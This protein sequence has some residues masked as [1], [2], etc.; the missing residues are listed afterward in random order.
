MNSSLTF[1]QIIQ[2]ELEAVLSEQRQAVFKQIPS[3]KFNA[4]R[5]AKQLYDAKG[6]IIDDEELALKA[7]RQIKNIDQYQQVFSALKNMP[8]RLIDGGARPRNIAAY[9]KSF[10]S[11]SDRIQAAIHLYDVL[12][13]SHY[14]WTIKKLV[15]Y[16]DLKSALSALAGRGSRYDELRFGDLPGRAINQIRKMFD[17]TAMYK[18]IAQQDAESERDGFDAS[19]IL[20]RPFVS[21]ELYLKHKSLSA[22]INA[23]GGLRE[24]VYSPAGIGVT[25]ATSLIPSPWTQIPTRILFAVL[26]IDDISRAAQGNNEA[27]LDIIWDSLGIIGGSSLSKIGKSIGSKFAALLAWIKN[28]GILAKIS[29]K[30]F[31]ILF[32]T[33]QFISKT[34]LGPILKNGAK[35]VNAIQ[36]TIRSVI[37]KALSFVKDMLIKLKNMPQPIK[38]WAANAL[39][40]LKSVSVEYYMNELKPIFDT[41]QLLAKAVKELFTAPK[42]AVLD[43]ARRLGVKSDWVVGV[44][45]GAQAAWV[46]Q[47]FYSIPSTLSWWAEWYS[48]YLTQQESYKVAQELKGILG[49]ETYYTFKNKPNLNI[50]M[51]FPTDDGV[52]LSASYTIPTYKLKSVPGKK[53]PMYI[54]L[55]EK[56]S[57][58]AKIAIPSQMRNSGEV[59]EAW[60]KISDIELAPKLK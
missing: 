40:N 17:D 13:A 41:M 2:E 53:I 39:Q 29:R 26:V 6:T 52:W 24:M 48:K 4:R 36:S 44:A 8:D 37:S 3:A 21:T 34:P 57:G 51:Y 1:E 50:K 43:V 32:D 42:S 20:F 38:S 59:S 15:S 25:T 22:W 55:K 12:P 19:D 18:T 5:I 7:I 10:L 14:N 49:S 23:P 56:K 45:H 31:D 47:M 9:L 33:I 60:V 30:M 46:A 54:I 58:Y 28:G 27:W 11:D 16:D 35:A